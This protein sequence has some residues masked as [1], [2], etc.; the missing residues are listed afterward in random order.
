MIGQIL[1]DMRGHKPAWEGIDPAGRPRRRST[2]AGSWV[3]YFLSDAEQADGNDTYDTLYEEESKGLDGR[4]DIYKMA[5]A[6]SRDTSP[7]SK[8]LPKYPPTN[9]FYL[10]SNYCTVS[11][12]LKGHPIMREPVWRIL[13]ALV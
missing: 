7:S 11:V 2:I 3:L 5:R 6:M 10:S 1:I 13:G 4:E 8:R 9:T 12:S